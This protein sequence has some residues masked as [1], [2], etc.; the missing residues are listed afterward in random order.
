MEKPK[1][2]SISFDDLNLSLLDGPFRQMVAKSPQMKAIFDLIGR[3]AGASA[4]ILITGE[5]GTGKEMLA[6]LI[7]RLGNRSTAPFIVV[8]CNHNERQLERALFGENQTW[9]DGTHSF[10]QGLLADA[11]GGVLF[12]D[13]ISQMAPSIQ[14]KLHRF[15]QDNRGYTA[16]RYLTNEK[17]VRI[18][19]ASQKNLK[20]SI[21]DGDF[22]ENLYQRLSVIPIEIPSLSQRPEDI[23]P[24]T[25]LFLRNY[26]MI[27]HVNINGF[28][29]PALAR[30]LAH[31]WSDNVRELQHMIERAVVLAHDPL[32]D[33]PDL[34]PT[35]DP[36][37]PYVDPPD[38][39]MEA[40][41]A[42]W[43]TLKNLH[44]KY[45]RFI[46]EKTGG[47]KDQAAHILGLSPRTLHRRKDK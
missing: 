1:D 12:L 32:I 27:N 6:R 21:R 3:I 34:F 42:F 20:L 26:A 43:P 10:T 33:E 30:L 18:I 39:Q 36:A 23:P 37:T 2:P 47:S 40:T 17:D 31:T 41:F 16:N 11:A 7:H 4:N 45:V 38:S 14:A 28:T 22:L 15:I 24:L 8:D 13:D 19:S 46:L 29:K 9:S 25:D 5:S 35:R 44:L